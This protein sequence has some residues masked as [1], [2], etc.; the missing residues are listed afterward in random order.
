MRDRDSTVRSRELGEALRKAME[1]TGLTG[2]QVAKRLE[3]SPSRVS[4]LL[5]GKRGGS[6]LDVVAFMAVCG[7]TGGQRAHLLEICREANSPGWLQRFG[8]RMPKQVRTLIDHETEAVSIQEFELAF[9]PGLLQTAAYAR[10][11]ISRIVN[12]PA[13]EVEERVA[14]RLARQ[15]ILSRPRPPAFTF[16][17]HEFVLH[18][19][20]GGSEVMSEQLHELLRLSV[21]PHIELRVVPAAPGAHAG[22]AGAFRLMGF[23]EVRPVV[24]LEGE[25]SGLFL[26]EPPEVAA[27][28]HIVAA[29]A[30]TALDEGQSKAFIAHLATD[31]YGEDH[32]ER[33]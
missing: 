10:N 27:Y 13:N 21:R 25:T 6:E 5:N 16:F 30:E 24:Y 11:V 1:S 9:V 20:V 29:L 4:R 22:M 33:A 26:E 19:P 15:A 17:I 28:R 3:W 14:A 18:L 31:L 2:V 23:A 8:D 7:V 12:V 32:D